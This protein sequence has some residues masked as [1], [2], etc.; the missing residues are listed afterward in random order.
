MADGY[1]PHDTFSPVGVA[2]PVFSVEPWGRGVP[3]VGYGWVGTGRVLY[4]YTT[5]D[6]PGPIFSHILSL[7]PYLRPNEAEFYVIYEVSQI[8]SRIGPRIDPESTQNRPS[9]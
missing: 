3:G 8:G 7:R 9:E 1:E 2:V 6:P 4:R 5:R